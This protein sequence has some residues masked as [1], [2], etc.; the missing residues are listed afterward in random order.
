MPPVTGDDSAPVTKRVAETARE[1]TQLE[2]AQVVRDLAHDDQIERA[3]GPFLRD[4]PALR[5]RECP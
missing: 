4:T 5:P 1:S 2:L 3:A